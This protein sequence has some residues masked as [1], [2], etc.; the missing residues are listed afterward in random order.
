M[1]KLINEFKNMYPKK[2]FISIAIGDSSN[3]MAMLKLADYPCVVKSTGNKKL[4]FSELSN[5]LIIS[6]NE[7]PKGWFECLENVFTK[8]GAS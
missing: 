7:A 2:E 4:S 5:D 8:I 3:D 1:L 6:K